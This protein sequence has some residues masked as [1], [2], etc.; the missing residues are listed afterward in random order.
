MRAVN[1][2]PSAVTLSSRAKPN[3][4]VI[5]AA[6]APF[7]AGSL[8]IAGYAFEHSSVTA[9][10][11]RLAA[12]QA[13]VAALPQRATSQRPAELAL[14]VEQQ[15][16]HLALDQAL[17]SRIPWDTTLVQVARVLPSDVWLTSLNLNSPSPADATAPAGVANPEAFTIAGFTYSQD[18]VAAL[19]TRLQ[20]LPILSNV[21]LA[22]TTSSTVGKKAVVEFTLNAEIAPATSVPAT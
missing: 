5:I 21:T 18:S 8:V 17:T 20:L 10:R 3:A 4:A 7:L 6:A 15:A 19:M 22:T 2:L 9:T 16:R 12:L 13:Q 14:G 11:G 1:L